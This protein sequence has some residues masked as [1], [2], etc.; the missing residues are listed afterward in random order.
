MQPGLPTLDLFSGIGGFSYALRSVCQT[1]AYCEI[2]EPCVAV[3]R[4]LMGKG[5][6]DTAPVYKDV[7][8]LS[9]T[10]LSRLSRQPTLITA[11]SPCQDISIANAKPTGLSGDR[12]RLVEEVLRLSREMQ[13][14]KY[15]FFENSPMIES[16]GLHLLQK[17]L[18]R[19]GF[20]VL[21][22]VCRASDVGA[23]HERRRWFCI[24]Y[25]APLPSGITGCLRLRAHHEP[26]A[27]LVSRSNGSHSVRRC[28]MLGNS[29]VPHQVKLAWNTFTRHSQTAKARV[30]R[31][32][33]QPIVPRLSLHLILR[34]GQ[35]VYKKDWWPTPCKTVW[36][37]Y[38]SLTERSTGV[39]SNAVYYEV[40]TQEKYG[41]GFL[42]N[43][44]YVNPCFVEWLMGYPLEYT[45]S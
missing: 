8:E 16:R 33:I 34:Q 31:I 28:E 30:Q 32:N 14:V 43:K 11:G 18:I 19:Q 15:I 38:H 21:H 5:L 24:A 41:D 45:Y 4:S 37:Q 12:S 20:R 3:L 13:S 22:G 25:K 17:R 35:T 7:R 9:K 6:I 26:C 27:R 1:V 2:H 23:L 39:L 36:V 44:W 29:V 10:V 42:F 40:K